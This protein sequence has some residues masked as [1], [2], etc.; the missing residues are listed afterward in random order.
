M[1]LNLKIID[2]FFSKKE[3]Q[4][5]Q[6]N[7]FNLD[8]RPMKN[9]NGTYGFRHTFDVDK[10]NQWLF[11][12][13]KQNFFLN[14]ELKVVNASYHLRHNKEKVMAHKDD[15]AYN[16]ILYLK[17]QQLMY[18][19]TGFYDKNNNLNTYVG[20]VENRALFFD[21]RN[22]LHTTLPALGESSPRHTINIFYDN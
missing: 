16:F 6:R 11:D 15:C 1:N 18:N 12:K 10:N 19:G 2:N 9:N 8:M 20:F 21:G 3:F 17:G 14:K 5:L 13:I 7:V 22:N 4:I